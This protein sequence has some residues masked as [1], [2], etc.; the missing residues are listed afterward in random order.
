MPEI[1]RPSVQEKLFADLLAIGV[2]GARH[3]KTTQDVLVN[4]LV[5]NNESQDEVQDQQS[6]S[7][8]GEQDQQI[9]TECSKEQV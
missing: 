8:V 6:A 2:S 1:L 9:V 4:D 7:Q 3:S 5:S